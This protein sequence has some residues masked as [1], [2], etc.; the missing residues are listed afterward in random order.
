[1]IIFI[2]ILIAIAGYFVLM[3]LGT[4]FIGFIIRGLFREGVGIE[5]NKETH[6]IIKNEIRKNYITNDILTFIWLLFSLGFMYLLY[7]YLNIWVV[8]SLILLMISRIPD[9]L[10]EINEGKSINQMKN[11][12][13]S[14][15]YMFASIIGWIALPIIWW[16]VYVYMI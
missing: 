16:A 9:L 8:I 12:P 2:S 6:P 4:N 13:K 11:V 3:I 7:I 14:G 10:L 15:T 1:M 5:V